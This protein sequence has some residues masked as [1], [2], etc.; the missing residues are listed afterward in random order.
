MIFIGLVALMSLFCAPAA[1]QSLEAT[2][3]VSP[4]EIFVGD[5]VIV[6][7]VFRTSVALVDDEN[8]SEAELRSEY[9][10]FQS[11]ADFSNYTVNKISLSR[12]GNDYNLTI[13]FVPWKPGVVMFRQFD[14]QDILNY[15]GLTKSKKK[16]GTVRLENVSVLSISEKTHSTL[17]KQVAPPVLVPGTIY[18][19]YA[20]ILGIILL[21]TAL[22]FLLAHIKVV[23]AFLHRMK[24]VMGYGRNARRAMKKVRRL[25]KDGSLSDSEF[26]EKLQL[27][28]RDYLS[29]RFDRPFANYD[30]REL[31][32]IF[33]ELSEEAKRFAQKMRIEELTSLF[34]R[35]DYIRYA[36]GSLDS[37]LLP[38][39]QHEAALLSGEREEMS[40]TVCKAISCLEGGVS[41]A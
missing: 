34:H 18:A 27:V 19:V 14:I 24:I 16:K 25:E 40:E 9:P 22:C 1:A 20:F 31:E 15:S 38:P 23:I 29:Y 36:A 4:H 21:F 13:S 37:K 3:I 32:R 12:N 17:L 39:A 41:D 2:Q 35:T 26:C 5:N 28:T 11:A 7:Y 30:T 8:F 10:I 6:Q 33:A